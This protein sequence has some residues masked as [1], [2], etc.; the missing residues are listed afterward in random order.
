MMGILGYPKLGICDY[1][2]LRISDYATLGIHEYGQPILGI[3]DYP[4]LGIWGY[5]IL[6]IRDYPIFGIRDIEYVI[7]PCWE[8]KD[9]HYW[10]YTD[11]RRSLGGSDPRVYAEVQRLASPRKERVSWRHE[12]NHLNPTSP[13]GR[14]ALCT[15]ALYTR[16][17]IYITP[18]IALYIY[19]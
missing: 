9:I 17:H 18:Y 12:Q 13:L 5:P 11:M 15:G 6:G 3:Q 1:A 14:R 16:P 4:I 7:I 19:I 10:E 2:I 8:H